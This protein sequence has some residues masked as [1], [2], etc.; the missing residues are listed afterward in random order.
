MSSKKNKVAALE[1]LRA[2]P[3]VPTSVLAQSDLHLLDR[4]S[5]AQVLANRLIGGLIL[6]DREARASS[7]GRA[8]GAAAADASNG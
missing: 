5:P 3:P 2:L 6:P 4:V 1:A 8:D 7:R